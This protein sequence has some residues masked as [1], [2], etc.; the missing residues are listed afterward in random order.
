MPMP[1][2]GMKSHAYLPDTAKLRGNEK[3]VPRWKKAFVG[4]CGLRAGCGVGKDKAEWLRTFLALPN[5]VPAHDTFRRVFMLIDPKDFESRF[6]YSC[7]LLVLVSEF[8]AATPI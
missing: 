7:D 4:Q 8:T 5:G 2:K 1:N 6:I 3:A